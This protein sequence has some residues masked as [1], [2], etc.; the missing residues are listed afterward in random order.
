MFIC[1]KTI[2]SICLNKSV[3]PT[4]DEAFELFAET[5]PDLD[6]PLSPA[7]APPAMPAVMSN[8]QQA[9][10]V[11]S[12]ENE[13]LS[14]Q[15]SSSQTPQEDNVIIVDPMLLSAL[16]ASSSDTPEFG[17]P[18]HDSLAKLWNPLLKKG[19]SKEERDKLLKENLI[20]DNC[21]LLQAPKLNAEITAA[22]SEV[23]RGRD[24]K[25]LHF[26]QQLGSGLSA[27]N[28]AMHVL[29]TTDD[30]AQALK[31]LGDGCRLLSDG[32]F[33]FTKDRLK[34]IVPSLDKNFTHIIQDSER[35]ETLFGSSLSEKIKASKAI[36][37]QGQQIKKSAPKPNNAPTYAP[38]SRPTNPGNWSGPPRYPSNRGGRG[39]Y[40]RGPPPSAPAVRRPFSTLTSS[41]ARPNNLPKN[42]RAPTQ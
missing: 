25:I 27:I 13:I 20:P 33:A 21:R 28:R 40:R 3:I 35:D 38:A 29:L 7:A 16:G 14:T 22:V 31:Y 12:N 8:D 26:Q 11:V 1:I 23:V 37:R 2:N 30:K 6:R 5:G 34:L 24:K 32:H 36:D 15:P 42:A 10:P 41:Q 18:I 19:L 9:D 39:G 17:D 4:D